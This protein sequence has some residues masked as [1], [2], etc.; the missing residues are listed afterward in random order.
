MLSLLILIT[1]GLS[2]LGSLPR[3]EDPRIDTRNALI[4]TQYPGASAE[5]VEALVSDV[6]EDRLREMNSEPINAMTTLIAIGP[7]KSPMFP[8]SKKIGI[9]PKIVVRVDAK[10]GANK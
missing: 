1:A 7:T 3:I 10:R 6:L 9:K 8:S 2:A 4:I 5:R